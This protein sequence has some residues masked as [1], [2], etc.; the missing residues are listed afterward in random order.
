MGLPHIAYII[1]WTSFRKMLF[2]FF[3]NLIESLVSLLKN[4][5]IEYVIF[6]HV[7]AQEDDIHG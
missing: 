3:F 5:I 1:L 4:H 6:K 2:F 7:Q